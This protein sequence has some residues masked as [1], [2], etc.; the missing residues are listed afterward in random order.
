MSTSE[1][2]ER[3]VQAVDLMLAG[4]AESLAAAPGVPE[5]DA[6]F[7]DKMRTLVQSSPFIR[8][9]FVVGPD[10]SLTY[11][12]NHPNTPRVSAADRDYFRA[13]A[14]R[15]DLGLYIGQPLRSRR[16]GTWFVGMS[17]RIPSPDGRFAGVV[18]TAVEPAYFERLYSSL[19]LGGT[20]ALL[21]RLL[22]GPAG[23]RARAPRRSSRRRRRGA[24][25]P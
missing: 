15:D 4:L 24:R 2:T 20:R 9:L 6:A 3:T 5:H 11:G 8:A 1:Q 19:M 13:H 18:A 22:A 16:V 21:R 17:R 12:T 7:Q 10:G 23:A 14:G 25:S